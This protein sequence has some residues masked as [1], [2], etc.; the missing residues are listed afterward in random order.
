MVGAFN[1]LIEILTGLHHT[2]VKK[3]RDIIMKS[4]IY[5]FETDQEYGQLIGGVGVCVEVDESKFGKTKYN[6]GRHVKGVSS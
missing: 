3:Y 5:D 6:K 4:I 1:A 2:T